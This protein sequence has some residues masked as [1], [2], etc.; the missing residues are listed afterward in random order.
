MVYRD[1]PL[2]TLVFYELHVAAQV[3]GQPCYG[4]WY[5][6]N[7]LFYGED[8]W[9]DWF[10]DYTLRL[11][12]SAGG[13]NVTGVGVRLGV[14]DQCAVWCNTYGDGTYHTP[15]PYFDMISMMLVN[16]SSIAWNIDQFRRFQDNFPEASG[17]VRIDSAIDV[18]P[19][20]STTLVIGDSTRVDLNMNGEGGIQPDLVSVPGERRASVYLLARVVAG[21]HAGS[22]DPA[23]GDPDASDGIWSPHIGTAVV[24]GE[25]WNVAI[26]DTAR[27]QGTP[28]PGSWAF[29][30]ADDYFE[31]GDV[32][33]F[34]YRAIS[35]LGTVSTR[36]LWAA[37]ADPLLREHY[38]LRCLPTA[39]VTMLFCDDANTTLP[40]WQEAFT[41]NG[42]TDF[43][44]YATQAPSSG[45]HNGLGGRAEI[46]D[47]DQYELIIWDSGDLPTYTIQNALPDDIAFDDV[48]LDDWLANSAHNTCL[49][50]MGN[51]VATDL[52]D[53][54][55]FLN[56]ALGAVRILNGTYYDDLT[57]VKMPQGV[58]DAPRPGDRRP[59][60][61]LHRGR[62][63]PV[64][65]EP[66]PGRAELGQ[67]ARGGGFRLGSDWRQS[68]QGG[69]LQPGS[70][71]QWPG[72]QSRRLDEPHALQSVQLCRGL[73]RG[74][75]P[76][77]WL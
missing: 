16:S 62:G 76:W 22:T 50:V 58:R 34:Y 53:E 63:L 54:P 36:P 1:L 37:S 45:L 32:L 68:G 69:H 33:E 43:D 61:L 23:M 57:G 14:V 19:T 30:F 2:N 29:D 18:E 8:G 64:D 10:L 49:W 75:R 13:G 74:L 17:K 48:L 77:Q 46:G 21:P 26:A 24:N 15:A 7:T 73:G 20:N 51:E 5:T 28:S 47:I 27:Y 41:Y 11:N 38:L 44:I 70:G 65:R 55:S 56:E 3:E 25:T 12:M 6:N 72:H 67:P 71:W 40:W 31:P 66:G 9:Q 39:G 35:A 60:S 52:A 4:Q 42:Y 59:R